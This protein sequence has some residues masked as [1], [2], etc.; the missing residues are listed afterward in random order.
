[1][2][3]ALGLFVNFSG[4]HL[5]DSI[6]F[7]FLFFYFFYYFRGTYTLTRARGL[8]S[9]GLLAR[10][11]ARPA[12]H[13]AGA[14]QGRKGTEVGGASGGGH[15]A[16]PAAA[17]IPQWTPAAASWPLAGWRRRSTAALVAR[18]T[19]AT[20]VLQIDGGARAADPRPPLTPYRLHAAALNAA[21]RPPLP[22]PELAAARPVDRQEG[23]WREKKL[24]VGPTITYKK[25]QNFA[26]LHRW[27]PLTV[28]DCH[29]SLTVGPRCQ[30]R[31]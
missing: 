3:L 13:L 30:F 26:T 28:F 16:W 12:C 11:G 6:T 31:H 19:T 27:P 4:T 21:T 20:L 24:T 25:T 18:R 7:L 15:P 29:V 9:R 17:A 2:V 23:V 22:K 1:L 8:A 14:R 10:G 5:S